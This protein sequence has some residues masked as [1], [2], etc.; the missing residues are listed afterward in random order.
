VI[1]LLDTTALVDA[2]RSRPTTRLEELLMT[3]NVLATS[4]VNIAELYAGLRPGEAERAGH[5]LA[6][7]ECY[8][9]TAAVGRR[10]GTLKYTW[11]RQ[12]KTLS[13]ADVLVAA[14]A[15]EHGLTLMTDN[16][17]DFPMAEIRFFPP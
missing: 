11:A 14:T 16:R 5:F 7:L 1:V 2:T 8:P 17:K 9:V 4:A 13:L 6:R 3:R 15:I 10:A 12:G